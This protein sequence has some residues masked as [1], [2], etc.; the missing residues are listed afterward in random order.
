MANQEPYAFTQNT[1]LRILKATRRLELMPA[2][3]PNWRR[4]SSGGAGDTEQ[5]LVKIE[6]IVSNMGGAYNGTGYGMGM[7]TD[8]D[9][10]AGEVLPEGALS[11]DQSVLILNSEEDGLNTH[12]LQIDRYLVGTLTGTTTG[13][14][15]IPIVTVGMGRAAIDSPAVLGD[16]NE[17]LTADTQTWQRDVVDGANDHGNVPV[18]I[19][20]HRAYYDDTAATPAL[21]GV[22]KSMLF[23]ASGK[24]YS[25][26]A[27]HEYIIDT[28]TDC[29]IDGGTT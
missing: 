17:T 21:K 8:P 9:S 27:D 12:W 19:Y 28:P 16:P 3:G 1:A 29:S 4:R 2:G 10:S 25:I 7:N 14:L 20:F 15:S 6:S 23:D 18:R 24:L 5:V 11:S 22:S 26:G 13:T